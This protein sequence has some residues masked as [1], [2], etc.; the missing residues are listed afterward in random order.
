MESILTNKKIEDSIQVV[1]NYKKSNT[2]K[3]VI[4]NYMDLQNFTLDEYIYVLDESTRI[5][6]E[7]KKVSRKWAEV[8]QK[9]INNKV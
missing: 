8:E 9:Y 5:I 2:R 4:K 1:V 3:S 6:N 7:I